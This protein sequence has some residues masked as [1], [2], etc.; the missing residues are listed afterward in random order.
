[1]THTQPVTETI[2]T[3]ET[4]GLKFIEIIMRWDVAWTIKLR[5]KIWVVTVLRPDST[6]RCPV[7]WGLASLGTHRPSRGAIS[8]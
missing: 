7:V 1:M 6:L 4:L 3:I 2:E 5:V 8:T